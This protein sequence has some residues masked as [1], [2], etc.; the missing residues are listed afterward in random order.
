MATNQGHCLCRGVTYEVEGPAQVAFY[1]HCGRCRRWTGS[2][3]AALM[4][5][6]TDQLRLTSGRELVETYREAGFVSRSFCRRCGTNLFGS[7]SPDAR[8][9]VVLMG[10]LEDDPGVRPTMHLHVAFKAPWHEITD[11]LPRWAELP[12]QATG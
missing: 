3:V 1:C 2:S 10:T 12:S 9:T 5:V 4:V 8:Q 7:P 11:D 6:S